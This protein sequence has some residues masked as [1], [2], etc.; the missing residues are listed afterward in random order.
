MLEVDEKITYF[1]GISPEELRDLREKL[2]ERLI[3]VL[4]GGPSSESQISLETGKAIASALEGLGY[5]VKLLDFSAPREL[6]E[7]LIKYPLDNLLVFVALHGQYGEDGKVQ[8]LLESLNLP[9]TGSDTTGSVLGM[10]KGVA[11]QIL[12]SAGIRVPRTGR[13]ILSPSDSLD[14][15]LEKAE[16]LRR[17]L[18]LSYPLVVK[19]NASGSTVGVSIVKSK[20]DLRKALE[21]AAAEDPGEVLVQEFIEGRELTIPVI[22]GIDGAIRALAPLEIQPKDGFYDYN[23][24]YLSEE[25]RYLVPAPVNDEVKAQMASIGVRAFKLLKCGWLARADFRYSEAR[26]LYLLELN[27][28]PGM[29]AHSLVPKSANYLG[30][31]FEHLAEMLAL[32]ALGKFTFNSKRAK[33]KVI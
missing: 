15:L 24:K 2:R 21:E 7:K 10:N 30:I 27:T 11:Y 25:T 33:M 20:R 8:G 1:L 5:K 19:P 28:I 29:T 4:A 3:L 13:I 23:A 17:S 26:G 18:G 31:S 22:E 6:V 12:S 9:Y 32:Q 14:D 16:Y